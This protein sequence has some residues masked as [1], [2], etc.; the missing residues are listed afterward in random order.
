M[1]VKGKL[2]GGCNY[3]LYHLSGQ[4]KLGTTRMVGRSFKGVIC[5]E[6][7]E[8]AILTA[9]EIGLYGQSRVMGDMSTGNAET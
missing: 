5:L 8:M 1:P 2:A 4:S 7:G 3:L 9:A 6:F